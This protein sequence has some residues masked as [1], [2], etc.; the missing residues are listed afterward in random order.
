M[1]MGDRIKKIRIS[2]K[3]SQKD[4]AKTMKIPVSTLANYENNHREPNLETIEKIAAALEVSAM[5]ILFDSLEVEKNIDESFSIINSYLNDSLSE[6]TPSYQAFGEDALHFL[7]SIS[8][9]LKKHLTDSPKVLGSYAKMIEQISNYDENINSLYYSLV[10]ETQNTPI[11]TKKILE[12]NNSIHQQ[13]KKLLLQ[14]D[15]ILPDI[16][17]TFKDKNAFNYL[18]NNGINLKKITDTDSHETDKN[19]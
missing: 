17:N 19:V 9:L 13:D 11:S 4:L 1:E 2:K 5:E 3:I 7:R 12:I 18:L 6:N 10:N 14:I 16:K 8:N 15:E